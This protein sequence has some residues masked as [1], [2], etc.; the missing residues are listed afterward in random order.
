LATTTEALARALQFHQAGNLA[1]AEQMYRQILQANPAEGNALHL[2]GMLAH[3]MGQPQAALAL[4]GQAVAVLPQVAEFHSNLGGVYLV[5]GLLDEAIASYEQALRLRPDL[6]E[7]H[8]NL[9]AAL[10]QQR[11]WKEADACYRQALALRPSYAEAHHKLGYALAE[12]GRFADAEGSYRE[13]LRLRP[14]SADA[15]NHLGTAL[16]AQGRLAEAV[17]SFREALRLEPDFVVAHYNLGL[18]LAAQG[19]HDEAIASYEQAVRIK[20]DYAEALNNLANAYRDQGRLDEAIACFRKAVAANPDLQAIHSNLLYTVQ[21]DADYDPATTF[22]EHLRWAEQFGASA[23]THRPLQPINRDPGR[24]LRIGYV[25]AD[26]H[27]HVMGRYSEAI[28]GAHDRGRF[29]VFCYANVD[30]PDALTQ[31]LK[32]LA[33]HWRSIAGMSD[34]RAGDLILQERI[35]VLVDLAGHTAGNRLG[36]FAGK[37]APIQVT[38]FGYFATTGLAAMDYRLTDTYCDPPGRTEHYHTEKLVRMPGVQWYYVPP[39]GPEVGPL[40]VRQAGH[41]TFG[42]FN[43]LSKVTAAMIGLWSQILR[44]LPGSR[45]VVMAGAGSAADERVLAAFGGHGVGNERVRL[46]GRQSRDAYFR[47]YQGVDICLDTFPFTGCNTTADA[48]W[49]GVPVV[50]LAGP[51][52]VTRQGVATLVVHGGLGDLVTETPAAYVEAATRLAQDLPRLEEL[53]SQLRGRMKCSLGDVRRFTRD[54]EAAYRGMWERFCREE[55][56]DG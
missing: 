2:L 51:S 55:H 28:V 1:Q 42:C 30:H 20:P 50:S 31:R 11:K 33:D 29:E 8:F 47:L 39:S 43:N 48:L 21:F 44:S 7:L 10:A 53:R 34:A 23:A 45:M 35:D 16:A 6:P 19:S 18:A 3:Q 27:E 46:M 32:A 52:C 54:L 24:R 22:A 17:P 26:F 9:G 5:L 25:S 13:A 41:V 37:P 38:H 4:I 40:P 14:D 49:M 12:E 36:V 56:G 15:F